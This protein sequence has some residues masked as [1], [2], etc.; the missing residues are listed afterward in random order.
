[1]QNMLTLVVLA[2]TALVV[3]SSEGSGNSSAGSP[4]TAERKLEPFFEIHVVEAYPY[5]KDEKQMSLF[6]KIAKGKGARWRQGNRTLQGRRPDG[7]RQADCDC[8]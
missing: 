1:M 2:V 5:P 8:H 6:G 3:G 7:Y 4:A